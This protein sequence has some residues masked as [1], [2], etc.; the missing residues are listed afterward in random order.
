MLLAI[1]YS[2]VNKRKQ[3][4]Y[5]EFLLLK[6]YRKQFSVN[7]NLRYRHMFGGFCHRQ[8]F[9]CKWNLSR[10]SNIAVFSGFLN[11]YESMLTIAIYRV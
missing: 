7:T 3:L 11:E 9:D 10:F 1:E 5:E 4:S 8:S 6:V 2:Y